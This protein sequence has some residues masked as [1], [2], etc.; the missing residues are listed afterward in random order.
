MSEVAALDWSTAP[1]TLRHALIT[2]L[3]TAD[4]VP[5]WSNVASENIS[6]KGSQVQTRLTHACVSFLDLHSTVLGS[7][8]L[9]A[10]LSL[11]FVPDFVDCSMEGFRQCFAGNRSTKDAVHE[12]IIYISSMCASRDVDTDDVVGRCE[13]EAIGGTCIQIFIISVFLQGFFP[14]L[15]DG[16]YLGWLAIGIEETLDCLHAGS[17]LNQAVY[18]RLRCLNCRRV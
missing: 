2:R 9:S 18:S 1:E 17:R 10:A 5:S 7:A 8:L 6:D 4:G 15:Q 16:Q 12:K 14:S 3:L 13:N 11:S